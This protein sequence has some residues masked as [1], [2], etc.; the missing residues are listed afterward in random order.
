MTLDEVVKR[1]GFKFEDKFYAATSGMS[2]SPPERIKVR[3]DGRSGPAI[4][5]EGLLWDVI[6]ELVTENAAL[7]S[8]LETRGRKR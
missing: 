3:E 8:Q 7:H 6:V 1:V 4:G 2:A 5:D